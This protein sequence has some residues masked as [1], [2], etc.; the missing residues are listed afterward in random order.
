MAHLGEFQRVADEVGEDLPHAQGVAHQQVRHIGCHG[1]VIAD[2]RRVG[3]R[4]EQRVHLAQHVLRAE[5]LVVQVQTTGLDLGQV[6]H[7]VDQTQQ[8]AAGHLRPRQQLCLVP[9]EGGVAQQVGHADH[10]VERRADLMAHVGQKF[11]LDAR[12]FL[13]FFLGLHEVGDVDAKSHRVA[14]GHAALNDAHGAPVQELLYKLHVGA[15]V[16]GQA[17]SHPFVHPAHGGRVVAQRRTRANDRLEGRT[18]K[19]QVRHVRVDLAV[20]FIAEHQ[21]VF[22][23]EQHKSLVDRVDGTTQQGLA[24]RH[25]LLRLFAG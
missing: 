21:A 10:G 17:L 18:P 5:G 25:D 8:R 24:V 7:I 20:F 11:A 9:G 1:D 3:L 12:G 6:E 22:R 13:R 15:A 2:A 19:H 16:G 14:V 4:S 23:I